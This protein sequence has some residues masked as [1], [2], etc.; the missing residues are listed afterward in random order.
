VSLHNPPP[1]LATSMLRPWERSADRVAFL[2]FVVLV[3]ECA[4]FSSGQEVSFRGITLRHLLI[5]TAFIASLPRVVGAR[6][7][8]IR[9][10]AVLLVATLAVLLAVGAA[11]GILAGNP[12]EA[13]TSDLT[14]LVALI[15]VPG[16]LVTLRT[17]R[18]LIV[19]VGAMVGATVLLG[20]LLDGASIFLGLYPSSTDPLNSLLNQYNFGGIAPISEGVYRVYVR[21]AIYLQVALPFLLWAL[22]IRKYRWYAFVSIPIVVFAAYTTFTRSLLLG[23]GIAVG[24]TVLVG[25]IAPRRLRARGPI[26]A[27]VLEVLVIAV[28]ILA[29]PS[30]TQ[31]LQERLE[32]SPT[33]S[34]TQG[35]AQVEVQS[36]ELRGRT[37]AAQ[38]TLI[39]ERPVFGWG[40]GKGIPE[41][42]SDTRSE[43]MELDYL[44]K[45]G[46]V[47]TMV[48]LLTFLLQPILRSWGVVRRWFR[49][50]R[51]SPADVTLLLAGIGLLS[52]ALSSTFNPYLNS[53]LG[54]MVLL[55]TLASGEVAKPVDTDEAIRPSTRT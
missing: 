22:T 47:G 20:M 14:T 15:L 27:G 23:M 21:S 33:S 19:M 38:V 9:N 46:L 1:G 25:I 28:L 48:L 32:P 12:R 10:V 42:R 37:V 17:Q 50:G 2:A 3:A 53:T 52:I 55:L 36:G 40:L 18:R 7:W 51:S 16:A 43:Y 44:V 24:L 4:I 49:D 41:V 8:L 26:L 45:L 13:I 39:R 35:Q 34:S 31:A 30:G 29:G 6:R 11:L 54:I 5:L